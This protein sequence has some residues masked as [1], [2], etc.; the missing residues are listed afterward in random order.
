MDVKSL[1]TN[2]R[3]HKGLVTV[4]Q[5]LL[6]ENA[7]NRSLITLLRVLHMNNFQF[8]GENYLQIGGTA[9]STHVA[10]SYTNFFMA[11]LEEKLLAESEYKLPLYLRYNTLTIYFS[12]SHTVSKTSQTWKMHIPQSNSLKDTP[13]VKQSF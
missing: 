11:R 10:P 6:R 5:T 9:M 8:N 1:Y 4:T 13:E 12:S 2:I 7:N 3:N